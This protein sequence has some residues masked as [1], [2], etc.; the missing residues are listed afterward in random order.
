MRKNM[1]FPMHTSLRNKTWTPKLFQG[2]P[3]WQR[4]TSRVTIIGDLRLRTFAELDY[5]FAIFAS[6]GQTMFE[7]EFTGPKLAKWEESVERR[8]VG[9]AERYEKRV[10]A[11]FRK[12]KVKFTEGYTLPEA[13]TPQLRVIYDSATQS[14]NNQYDRHFTGSEYHWREW[15]L[16]NVVFQKVRR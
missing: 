4:A 3:S 13:P 5:L 16:S 15:P 7:V 10:R 2:C 6:N 8:S 12:Y 1:R 14:E 11:H 9:A